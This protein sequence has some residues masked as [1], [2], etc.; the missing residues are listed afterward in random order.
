MLTFPGSREPY[1]EWY[2]SGVV[3]SNLR[4]QIEVEV[5]K[6]KDRGRKLSTI[7]RSNVR[8][9]GSDIKAVIEL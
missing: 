1:L 8:S 6:F 7:T 9:W 5:R 4:L 3:K 2:D